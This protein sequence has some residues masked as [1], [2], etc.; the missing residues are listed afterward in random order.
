[1]LKRQKLELTSLNHIDVNH[2]LTFMMS[3][4]PQSI[5]L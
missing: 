3:F 2:T 4:S 1:M 5:C